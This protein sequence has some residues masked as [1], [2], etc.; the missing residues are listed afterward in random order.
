MGFRD[1]FIALLVVAA[2]PVVAQSVD[3]CEDESRLTECYTLHQEEILAPFGLQSAEAHLAAGEEMYRA[4][5]RDGYGRLMVAVAAARRPGSS[6][7]LELYLPD[8]SEGGAGAPAFSTPLQASDWTHVRDSAGL[9]DRILQPAPPPP[10]PPGEGQI[11]V[12]AHSWLFVVESTNPHPDGREARLRRRAESACDDGV[13]GQ[14]AMSLAALAVRVLPPCSAIIA[15]RLPS[16]PHKLGVCGRFDGDRLAAAEVFPLFE[17]LG[18]AHS[19][20]GAATIGGLFDR[21]STID[22]AGQTIA[23][24]TAGGDA[25]LDASARAGGH[26]VYLGA[27]G[28]NRRQVRL[29][30][31]LRRWEPAPN[32]EGVWMHAPAE[33]LWKRR[34]SGQWVIDQVTVGRAAPARDFCPPNILTGAEREN[35]CRW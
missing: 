2:E 24:G 15:S 27:T 9:F 29:R 8:A 10:A 12:C 32:G 18:G 16:D 33:F 14:Y 17:E 26:F 31:V 23:P 3:P 34:D 13:T 30:A 6:P 5:F 7:V 22:W 21:D 11:T 20:E 35:H 25:W 1:A 28:D 19:V 4:M